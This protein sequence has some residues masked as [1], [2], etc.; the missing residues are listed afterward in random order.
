[1]NSIC[2]KDEHISSSA[3]LIF[4]LVSYLA[5]PVALRVLQHFL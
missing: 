2:Y 3:A 1:M 4:W 5:Y